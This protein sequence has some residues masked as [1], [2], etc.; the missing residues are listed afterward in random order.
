[1]YVIT[2]CGKA[3]FRW[4]ILWQT[5]SNRIY[6]LAFLNFLAA[7]T[8]TVWPESRLALPVFFSVVASVISYVSGGVISVNVPLASINDFF[9]GL[10]NGGLCALALRGNFK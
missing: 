9:I 2:S 10:L 7:F 1:V 5:S 3:D 4:W 8:V 6:V